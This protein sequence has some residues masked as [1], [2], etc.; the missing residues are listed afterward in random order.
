MRPPPVAPLATCTVGFCGARKIR[1]A[2]PVMSRTRLPPPVMSWAVTLGHACE[3]ATARAKQSSQKR[4]YLMQYFSFGADYNSFRRH[5][6]GESLRSGRQH[7]AWGAN[8][9]IVT[10]NELKPAKRAT[11]HRLIQRVELQ[12]DW[13]S[14][15]RFQPIHHSHNFAVL[16]PAW[17]F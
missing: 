2:P 12:S 1:A 9:R 17:R 7:K 6:Q 3:T 14:A 13:P 8:P 11:A 16:N 5:I 4:R 10:Q 15:R